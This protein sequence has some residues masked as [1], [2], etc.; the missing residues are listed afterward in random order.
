MPKYQ[1]YLNETGEIG[2]VKEVLHSIVYVSGLPSLKPNEVVVF[3]NGETGQ[4]ISISNEHSEVLVLSHVPIKVGQKVARTN[5]SLSIDISN[6]ILGK[7][8]DPLGHCL[9]NQNCPAGT[10]R[11]IDT[12]PPNLLSRT[13][14]KESLET[15]VSLV[16]LVIPIGKGQR[17][18][19]IGDRKTG[20][21]QFFIKTIVNQTQK[22]NICIYASVGKRIVEIK[23]ILNTLK[24]KGVLQNT[25]IVASASS[26][27]PGLIYLTPYTAMTIAEHFRDQGKDV[28]VI[29]DDLTTHAKY[30]RQI[31]LLAGRFPGRNSYP[32]DIFYLHSKLLERAGNF[33]TGSITCF[34]VAESI[35]GDLSGY[36][37]TNLM[38]ITDGHIFFD[39]ELANLGRRPPI[40]PFLSVTRVGGQAQTPLLRDITR[41][42]SSFLVSLEKLRDFV[43]FGAELSE[44]VLQKLKLGDRILEFFNQPVDVMPINISILCIAML[45]TGS[46]RN[47]APLQMKEK[48]KTMV[49]DYEKD[50]NFKNKIDSLI[51]STSAY[52]D[53]LNKLREG[54][55]G[56]EKYY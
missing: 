21:T 31:S 30:Y 14:I 7:T 54:N 19:V 47:Q 12:T 53:F 48:I 25:I 1:D 44:D 39:S 2:E 37:Q 43:H 56:Q 51:K 28:V 4:T 34:P 10:I 49:S 9:D 18:L 8:V 13:P 55:Y 3:D 5:K 40:N 27:A 36:I 45:W 15:G 29:L 32:G 41:D 22:E 33:K 42:L 16:D 17:E 46:W 20:K 35:L 38:S 11:E 50:A 26:D 6:A 23:E 52:S 24:K